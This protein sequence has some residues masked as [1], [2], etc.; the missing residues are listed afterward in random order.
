MKK[1]LSLDE[2]YKCIEFSV[3]P[4]DPDHENIFKQLKNIF[5]T[6]YIGSVVTTNASS[7]ITDTTAKIYLPRS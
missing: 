1:I 3:D 7:I 5:P 2:K 4:K 6:Y